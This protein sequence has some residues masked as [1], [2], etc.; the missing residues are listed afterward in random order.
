MDMAVLD[1]LV[2]AALDAPVKANF[3]ALYNLLAKEAAIPAEAG[4]ALNTLWEGLIEKLNPEAAVFCFR[5]A[6]LQ[7]PE[8]ELFRK[9]LV[10]S[11]TT[12][13]PPYLSRPP[14]MRAIGV[15]DEKLKIQEIA[16]RWVKLQLLKN[17]TIVF[18]PGSKRWVSSEPLTTSTELLSSTPS[19]VSVSTVQP[20][21]IPFSKR[22]CF[23]LPVPNSTSWFPQP[24]CPLTPV[25]TTSSSA[26]L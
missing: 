1:D 17:G 14:I 9:V 22:L 4:N 21:L 5:A 10:N 24:T 11:A 25:F 13:L 8:S 3:D 15:R 16:S 2:L 12:L 20:L 26:A 6:E 18:L 7:L 23:W 19:L